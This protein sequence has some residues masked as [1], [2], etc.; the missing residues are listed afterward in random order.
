MV[1]ED[2]H[3]WSQER[4][5]EINLTAWRRILQESIHQGTKRR[6]EFARRMLKEV[7]KDPEY[8]DWK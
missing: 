1:K 4:W 2:L 6:E 8:V 3:A 7:L 5:R